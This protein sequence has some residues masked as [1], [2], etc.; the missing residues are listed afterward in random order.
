VLELAV[1]IVLD[2]GE[3]TGLGMKLRVLREWL[4]GSDKQKR[5]LVLTTDGGDKIAVWRSNMFLE[6]AKGN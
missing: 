2:E 3:I 1:E 6:D 5:K 4:H